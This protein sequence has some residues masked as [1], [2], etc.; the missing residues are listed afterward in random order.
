MKWRLIDANALK[1]A[2]N[3][4]KNMDD[5]Y[6]DSNCVDIPF[7]EAFDIIDNAP[8]IEE[9]QKGKW[10]GDTDYESFQGSYEA[11]KCSI[12]GHSL[13][14]RD[15]CS[16]KYNFCPNCGSDMRGDI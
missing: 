10:I 2:F 11:Y 3:A 8:T 1:D 9:R 16:N 5:Y 12:C 4:W 15:Y 14:W 6:H 13:H 7:E